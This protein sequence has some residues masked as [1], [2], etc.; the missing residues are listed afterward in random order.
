[1]QI[2]NNKTNNKFIMMS[3]L[4]SGK[5]LFQKTISSVALIR[6]GTFEIRNVRILFGESKTLTDYFLKKAGLNKF[7]HFFQIFQKFLNFFHH[8]KVESVPVIQ[9]RK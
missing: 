6:V 2:N 9:N 4:W 5:I 8:V 1:M 7:S 3:V